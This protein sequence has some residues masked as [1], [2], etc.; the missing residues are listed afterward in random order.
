MCVQLCKRLV[1]L[2][3]QP[4]PDLFLSMTLPNKREDCSGSARNS[5]LFGV[6]QPINKLFY[7]IIPM[8]YE[9]CFYDAE[10]KTYFALQYRTFCSIS[11]KTSKKALL[12]T[13]YD[14]FTIASHSPAFEAIQVYSGNFEQRLTESD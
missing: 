3:L 11:N 4:S 8:Q 14:I 2:A 6:L 12:P 1:P 9:L 10:I 5:T 13:I 7:V